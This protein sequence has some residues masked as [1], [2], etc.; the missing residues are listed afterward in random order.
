MCWDEVCGRSG[1]GRRSVGK[2]ENGDLIREQGKLLD[3]TFS[4]FWLWKQ[5]R[6]EI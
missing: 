1:F 2:G 6:K 3:I 4:G 5:G